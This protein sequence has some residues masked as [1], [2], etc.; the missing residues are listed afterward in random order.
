MR[1]VRKEICVCGET[2]NCNERK[3]MFTVTIHLPSEAI[4]VSG[5]EEWED[6]KIEVEDG[7]IIFRKESILD[8]LSDELLEFYEEM[9]FSLEMVESILN[10]CLEETK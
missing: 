2:E 6:I 3:A 10:K 5:I 8:K 1:I 4:E 9:G 7:K